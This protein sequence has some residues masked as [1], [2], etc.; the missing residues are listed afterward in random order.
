VQLIATCVPVR[1]RLCTGTGMYITKIIMYVC[2]MHAGWT[3][4]DFFKLDGKTLY[5]NYFLLF[6]KAYLFVEDL[7]RLVK[8]PKTTQQKVSVALTVCLHSGHGTSKF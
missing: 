8:R 1:V 4:L 5:L 3:G 2:K 6:P 7:K